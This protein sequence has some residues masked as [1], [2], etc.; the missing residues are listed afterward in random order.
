[1]KDCY[2]HSTTKQ[3]KTLL[4][5]QMLEQHFEL[6]IGISPIHSEKVID[7]LM[8]HLV[9]G[10]T[11]REC[12]ERNDVCQSYFSGALKRIHVLNLTVCKL[13]PFYVKK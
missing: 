2:F 3:T 8:D 4:P 1:M 5:G 7:A 6:L 10:Y 11:K 12:C 9:L 13:I